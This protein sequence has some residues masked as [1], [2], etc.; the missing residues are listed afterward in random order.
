MC[1]SPTNIKHSPL[2]NDLISIFSFSD[3]FVYLLNIKIFSYSNE[4]NILLL[5][6]FNM[7]FPYI[8]SSKLNKSDIS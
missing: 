3:K 4:K 8:P 5:E 7:L 6:L 2:F 1:S